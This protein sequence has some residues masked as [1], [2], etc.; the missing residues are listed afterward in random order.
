M[1]LAYDRSNQLSLVCQNEA[2]FP[3]VTLLSCS[4]DTSYGNCLILCMKLHHHK[5]QRQCY[6][7]GPSE[8]CKGLND[9]ISAFCAAD[10]HRTVEI[11]P[12]KGIEPTKY[13]LIPCLRYKC[14]N[15]PETAGCEFVIILMANRMK[16]N[17]TRH[18]S[19]PKYWRW[20]L[21]SCMKK[22]LWT[23]WRPSWLVCTGYNA[24]SIF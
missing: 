22:L 2:A 7:G 23:R 16:T 11:R 15:K 9:L 4:G 8:S 21:C 17:Q 24:D 14:P 18:N 6:S 1:R 3:P 20:I 19:R 10:D 12:D 5:R 13:K